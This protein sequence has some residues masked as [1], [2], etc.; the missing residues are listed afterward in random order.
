MQIKSLPKHKRPREKLMEKGVNAVSDAELLAIILRTGIQGKSAIQMGKQLVKKFGTSGLL[1]IQLDDLLSIKGLGKV[2]AVQLL[3]ALEIARRAND[4]VKD[5]PLIKPEIVVNLL[6]DIRKKKREYFVSLY[7]NVRYRLIKKLVI[8]IGSLASTS[9]HPREVYKPAIKLSAASII[10]A[11]N[12]PSNDVSPSDSDKLLTNKLIKA[13]Q[14]LDIEL[15]DHLIV[16]R[17]DW[18]SM[19]QEGYI[20]D[21]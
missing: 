11:H 5:E 20:Q 2:K 17:S 9:V 6:G 12:H 13:G 18:L 19:K 3:A 21:R 7:L 16:S 15:V 14:L 4:T 1:K 8:S 10:V